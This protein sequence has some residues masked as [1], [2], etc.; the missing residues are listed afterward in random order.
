MDRSETKTH[1]KITSLRKKV[2]E[3]SLIVCGSIKIR[4]KTETI[5]RATET[6]KTEYGGHPHHNTK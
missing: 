2:I 5:S 6:I 3:N 1:F 4:T